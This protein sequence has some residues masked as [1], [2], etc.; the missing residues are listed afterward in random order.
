MRS[1]EKNIYL[2]R[3]LEE[4]LI[5]KPQAK[6]RMAAINVGTLVGSSAYVEMKTVG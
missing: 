1:P 6:L 4:T 3:K 5:Q 2:P